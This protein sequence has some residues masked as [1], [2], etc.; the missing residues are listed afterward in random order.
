MVFF[1]VFFGWVGGGGE[2]DVGDEP[3]ATKA[4]GTLY[5]N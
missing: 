2:E 1:G 3:L 4:I 5:I